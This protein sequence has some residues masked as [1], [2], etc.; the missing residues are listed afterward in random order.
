MKH[1]LHG[2][3]KIAKV[4]PPNHN[5]SPLS[6]NRTKEKV[7]RVNPRRKDRN[8]KSKPPSHL[9]RKMSNF[10]VHQARSKIMRKERN[11][12]FLKVI[13]HFTLSKRAPK[14]KR[15]KR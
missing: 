9:I 2:A 3:L 8:A 4:Q 5:R 7:E 14:I 15:S 1:V 13:L 11:Q 12:Q 6:T 10:R